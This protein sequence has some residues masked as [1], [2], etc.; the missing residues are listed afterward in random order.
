[1]MNLNKYISYCGAASRREAE[2]RIRGGEVTVNG[3]VELNPAYRVIST[4]YFHTIPVLKAA[5]G[6]LKNGSNAAVPKIIVIDGRSSSG[7][8]TLTGQLQVILDAQTIHMDHFFLPLAARSEERNKE[9]GGNLHY[10]RFAEEVLPHLSR[11]L[12]FSYGVFDCG[13]QRITEKKRIEAPTFRIV[14]GSYSHHPRFGDYADL[15]LFLTLDR[16][17]QEA[18]LKARCPERFRDF[19]EKWIPKEEAYFAA[20]DIQEK[21]DLVL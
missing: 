15:R 21:A 20:F 6:L 17:E 11:S 13:E 10:E 12:P 18:R 2:A 1:M 16:E 7:K 3:T 9:V 4:R 14:E 5:A 8:T 19:T